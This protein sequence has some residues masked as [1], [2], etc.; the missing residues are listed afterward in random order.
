MVTIE[1]DAKAIFRT[2]NPDA[3]S[4]EILGSFTGWH[5]R[6]VRMTKTTDGWWHAEIELSPGDHEFQYLVDRRDWLADYA[7]GGLRM[8]KFG[9][10]LSLLSVPAPAT[11][12]RTRTEY[13]L[14]A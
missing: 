7:A 2:F 5:D 9:S 10:W 1:R 3:Q 6:P 11:A 13:R 12:Q 8:G 4:I 14:A